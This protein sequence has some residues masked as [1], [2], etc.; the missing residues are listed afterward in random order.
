MSDKPCRYHKQV[1]FDECLACRTIVAEKSE[2]YLQDEL[3]ESLVT[4]ITQQKT[5]IKRLTKELDRLNRKISHGCTDAT[6]AECDNK[7]YPSV[8]SVIMVGRDGKLMLP[9]EYE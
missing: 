1:E 2:S 9:E 6:C 8:A 7:Q 4:L 5:E 3:I